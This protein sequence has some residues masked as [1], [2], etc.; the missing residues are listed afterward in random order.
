MG[1]YLTG[2]VQSTIWD[3]LQVTIAQQE[4]RYSAE[5]LSIMQEEQV[6]ALLEGRQP[7]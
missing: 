2:K 5:C 3:L 1:E 6:A 4:A 7:E